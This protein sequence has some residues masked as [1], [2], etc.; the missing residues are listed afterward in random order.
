[1]IDGKGFSETITPERVT[2]HLGVPHFRPT[3]AEE[4]NEIGVKGL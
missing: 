3:M 4:K 1:M 2:A